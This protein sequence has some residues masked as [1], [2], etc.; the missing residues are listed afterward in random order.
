MKKIYWV[1]SVLLI[2]VASCQ[3]PEQV[4]SLNNAG[5]LKEVIPKAVLTIARNFDVFVSVA[6]SK[7]DAKNA[8][9]GDREKT[10]KNVTP[11]NDEAGE[12]LYYVI[13]YNEGGFVI[14]SAEK[15]TIPILAFS[16]TNDFPVDKELPNGV[17][18]TMDSYRESIKKA[19]LSNSEPDPGILKEWERLGNTTAINEWVQSARKSGARTTDAPVNPPCQ[20]SQ[21]Y[22]TL[23]TASWGQQVS[24]NSQMP[25][26]FSF[27]C[28]GMPNGR[29]LTGCVATAMAEIMNFHHFPNNY[30]WS[31]MGAEKPETARLMRAAANSVNMT[32]DCTG[33]SAYGSAIP[34]GFANGFGYSPGAAYGP[35]NI[36]TITSEILNFA[37]PVVLGGVYP[38][39]GGHAWVCDGYYQYF[40]CGSPAAPMLRMNWGWDGSCNAFYTTSTGWDPNKLGSAY[41]NLVMV[42]NIKP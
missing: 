37:R 20:D 5:Q 30:N 27:G 7:D 39:L 9:T 32:Y 10:I 14:V 31:E 34:S 26:D 42:T 21:I 29:M 11:F 36:N 18:E 8:R 4:D 13:T 15:K 22:V 2:F 33:S 41:Q 3:R 35:Y 28:M 19:R 17:R 24:W 40:S 1:L 6:T 16:D 25:F 38:N 12:V 23:G